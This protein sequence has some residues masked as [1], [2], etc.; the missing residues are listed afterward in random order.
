MAQDSLGKKKGVADIAFLV[1]VSG[2]MQP[3]LDALKDN[4]A[5]LIEFMTNPGPNEPAVVNDWRIKVCGYRDAAADGSAWWEEFEFTNDVATARSQLDALEAKGG[6]D[7]PES[8][9][10]GLW[11]LSQLRAAEKGAQME[12]DAWRH[13]H[14]AARCVI[15]FTDASCHMTTQ[16]AAAGGA[17]FD[18]VA[19]EV[20]AARLRLSI[21]CPEADCYQSVAAIDKCEIEFVGSLSDAVSKM[22]EFSR[23]KA[24][25]RKTMQQLAKSI[26]VSAATPAL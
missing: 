26:S 4:I 23:D 19:R 5:S 1:D 13:H 7:E 9:L 14:D 21:Y 12:P 2:S 25:F 11:R 3:C 16:D 24:N 17:T 8:L 20:M 10:D 18:D 6:G 22:A 15:V